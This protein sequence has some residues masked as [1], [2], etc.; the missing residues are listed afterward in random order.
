MLEKLD[1]A[2]MRVEYLTA[3]LGGL[4]IFVIMLLVTTE[5]LMRRL[6]NAPIQGQIDFIQMAMVTFSVLCISYCYRQ[7]GHIRMDM[8]QKMAR[9]RMGWATHLFATIVALFVVLAILPGTWA[10][11][12]RAWELGDTTIGVG[13]PTW[14]SKLA[15]PVGLGILAARLMLELWVFGR[16]ILND[17]LKPIGV[18]EPPDPLE[19]MDA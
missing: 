5:V 18:P 8:L 11:F 10:H 9:G 3:W 2:L 19:D 4:T 17:K 1:K 12:M 7:A 14:P 13:L 15:V 16:L 6:F